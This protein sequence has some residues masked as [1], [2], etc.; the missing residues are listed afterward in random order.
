[1]DENQVKAF[2]KAFPTPLGFEASGIVIKRGEAVVGFPLGSLVFSAARSGGGLAE[3]TIVDS[4]FAAI[5][6][7]NFSPV[8]AG[9]LSVNGNT[10][11]LALFS[12]NGLGLPFPKSLEATAFGYGS[13][14][15]AIIG[16]GTGNGKIAIQ[17]ARIAGFGKIIA[18]ASASGAN[19]LLEF[20]ATHVV[21]RNATNI[22]SQVREIAG[23]KIMHIYETIGRDPKLA[24]AL[25]S[26][27]CGGTIVHI[28]PP[29]RPDIQAFKTDKVAVKFLNGGQTEQNL[30]T[31]SLFWRELPKWLEN[32]DLNLKKVHVVKGLDI[33]EVTMA[34]EKILTFSGGVKYIVQVSGW[35]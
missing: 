6:P 8:F 29:Y 31:A 23:D 30:E 7:A 9:G 16:G 12:A 21:D 3:F 34:F 10:T 18:I 17:L 24:P 13:K 22:E 1:M 20:G 2:I 14:S 5:V 19:E 11:A 32:G 28:I 26:N 27:E 33:D 4:R 15:I 25:L 35:E